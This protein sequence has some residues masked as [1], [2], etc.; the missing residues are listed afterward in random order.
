M[1]T[2]RD[3]VVYTA[4][5]DH[6]GM[7]GKFPYM[8]HRALADVV[9]M[10]YRTVRDSMHLLMEDS[11]IA[12]SSASLRTGTQIEVLCPTPDT[13]VRNTI[14][15]RIAKMRGEDESSTRRRRGPKM[16]DGFNIQQYDTVRYPFTQ[17]QMDMITASP[18]SMAEW[19]RFGLDGVGKPWEQQEQL[20]RSPFDWT[21]IPG[22][23]D[24]D[25]KVEKWSFRQMAG[26]Y[27][28]AISSLDHS[29]GLKIRLPNLAML[30]RCIKDIGVRNIQF[31][32]YV[33]V[34]Y[35]YASCVDSVY[36]QP[37]SYDERSLGNSRIRNAVDTVWKLPEEGRLAMIQNMQAKQH[38]QGAVNG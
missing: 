35:S 28:F 12:A 23:Q 10:A 27:W 29:R 17:E 22:A 15:R 3:F 30:I 38:P 34:M 18:K 37:V 7:G 31:Y 26:Y 19:I 14:T 4:L 20:P 24:D 9:G 1:L 32:A 6:L 11:W 16:P 13:R 25:L 2:H 36:G 5:L 21:S 8:G 33:N